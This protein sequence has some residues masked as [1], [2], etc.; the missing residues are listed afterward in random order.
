MLSQTVQFATHLLPKAVHQVAEG[1]TPGAWTATGTDSR[2]ELSAVDGSVA[3]GWVLF[4]AELVRQGTDFSARLFVEVAGK[5]PRWLEYGIPVTRKGKISEVL[6][7]PKGALRV[8]FQPMESVGTFVLRAVT[9]RPLGFWERV[10]IQWRR[11]YHTIFRLSPERRDK[12]GLHWYSPLMGL[13]KCYDK[14]GR[15]RGYSPALTYPEWIDQFD[16]LDK[17]D[18]SQI[19]GDIR[20]WSTKPFF[21]VVVFSNGNDAEPVLRTLGSLQGQLFDG[22]AL[23]VV[24]PDGAVA[25]LKARL[26]ESERAFVVPLSAAS[27]ERVS[28]SCWPPSAKPRQVWWMFLPAGAELSEHALYWFGALA[29]ADGPLRFIYSDHDKLDARGQ[30]CHPEFKP[31]WTPELLR[32]S[33]YIGVAAV[34]RADL[35]SEIGAWPVPPTTASPGHFSLH[36]LWLRCTERLAAESIRH[37]HAPLLHVP[38]TEAR[39][40]SLPDAIR[41][42]SLAAVTA[43][44]DRLGVGADIER[45]DADR[46]RIRYRLPVRLPTVS[47]LIPTRDAVSHLK[48][49]VESVL[50]LSSYA[51]LEV[52]IVDNQSSEPQACAYLDQLTHRP[53]VR[54]LRFDQA[55]NFSSINNFAAHAASGEALCL[56]NND[57]EVISPDWLEEMLGHLV[58]P[59]VGAVG[60][61]LLYS[62][63][64]VQHAGDAVGP[65]GCAQHFHSFLP[66][67]A[68]GYAGRAVLSQDLSAVTG[69][70][71][72]TWRHLY[73]ELGGLDE[74][75]LPIEYNDVDYCLRLRSNGHRVVWTP[76]AM[77]YHHESISRGKL[78]DQGVGRAKHEAAADYMRRRWMR[79]MANDPFYNPN[80]SYERPD[81]SL[82]HSPLVRQPW[83]Q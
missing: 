43:H 41:G 4:C 79:E 23:I 38:V 58:Q 55:F 25:N 83:R 45:L 53:R 33:D 73:L 57:T 47:I 19:R 56:L 82:S 64:R 6:L 59:E 66:G 27:R 72:L 48:A 67:D 7:L 65:G 75:N 77:L 11:V 1:A 32:S 80:L 37:L 26:P 63:G 81:F 71:L 5:E 2:L 36:G 70:C 31:D 39:A 62:D 78:R 22:F 9:I 51:K 40:D 34:V 52:I 18:R 49:C 21:S 12:A 61:K 60:A 35:L 68:M 20:L 30:R 44:L 69:A 24:V 15:Y 13:E 29:V 17:R 10:Y 74:V 14:T 8:H 42:A 50:G 3:G 54:V 46:F 76:H 28:T 16:T